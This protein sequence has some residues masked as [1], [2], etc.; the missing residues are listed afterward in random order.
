MC[1]SV[2]QKHDHIVEIYGAWIRVHVSILAYEFRDHTYTASMV[3]P[4]CL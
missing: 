1:L 4:S 3:I 2:L